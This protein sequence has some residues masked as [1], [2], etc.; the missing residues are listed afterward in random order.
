MSISISISKEDLKIIST[1][2]KTE[3]NTKFSR[4]Y[5]CLWMLNE[6]YLKKDIALILGVNI[7]TITDW[8]KIYNK[9]G[10]E[11]LGLLKYEGR[12]SSSLDK[13]KNKIEN[14]I[15]TQNVSTIKHLQSVLLKEYE[16]EIEHSWLYRYC[17]K[18]SI[19][20]I[21]SQD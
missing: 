18:N 14:T 9:S 4:R 17:K 5:Q 20:L 3:K 2:R 8:I 1:K 19:C 21:K 6:Q 10:L 13:F 12:R 11:G 15:R 16:I 7:D